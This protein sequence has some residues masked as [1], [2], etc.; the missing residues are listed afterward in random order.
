MSIAIMIYLAGVIGN[1]GLISVVICLFIAFYWCIR[2]I[3]LMSICN[4]LDQKNY[5][6]TRSHIRIFIISFIVAIVTPSEKTMYLMCAASIAKNV[7]D[8]PKVINTMDKVIKII[9][10]KLDEELAPLTADKG[11][12][13]ANTK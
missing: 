9:D 3:Q 1:I 6:N 2:H 7:S 4:S 5:D 13:N 8:N 12:K 10:A 11:A